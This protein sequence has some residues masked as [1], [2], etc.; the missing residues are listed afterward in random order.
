MGV[1]MLVCSLSCVYNLYRI[2]E[3]FLHFLMPLLSGP[4]THEELPVCKE[5]RIQAAVHFYLLARAAGA[6][7]PQP[8]AS[9]LDILRWRLPTPHLSHT[10]T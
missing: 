7:H 4:W 2:H 5:A 8:V 6:G 10:C 3:E 9:F 1:G